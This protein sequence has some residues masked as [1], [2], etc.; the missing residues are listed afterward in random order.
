MQQPQQ[1]QAPAGAFRGLQGHS[2]GFDIFSRTLP[3]RE[4]VSVRLENGW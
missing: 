1:L 4:N 2:K 3:A